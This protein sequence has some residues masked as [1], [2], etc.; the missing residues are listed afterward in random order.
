LPKNL[1]D[2]DVFYNCSLPWFGSQCQYKFDYDLSLSFTDILDQYKTTLYLTNGTCYRFLNNCDRGS[3]PSCFDWHEICD[4]K[5]DCL[6]EYR[7]HYGGQCI[8]LTFLKDNQVSIDCLDA[9]DE[10]D[11]KLLY[12]VVMNPHCSEILTFQCGN[13]EY[14]NV[15]DIILPH[16]IHHCLNRQDIKISRFMLT[17]MDYISN[18]NC[19]KA[20]YCA[21]HFN[22]KFDLGKNF[23]KYYISNI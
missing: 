19:Q 6:N 18:P 9:S 10:Q 17:S 7:C 20:F 11:Y 16:V 2:S 15:N 1:N 13:G 4:G 22:R 5:F 3:W 23:D 14:V 8:P 12:G 21:L